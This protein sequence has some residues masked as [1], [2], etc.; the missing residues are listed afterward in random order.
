VQSYIDSVLRHRRDE[1]AIML[2]PPTGLLKILDAE[3]EES[4]YGGDETIDEYPDA[5]D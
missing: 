5:D 2:N 3:T 4:R 1:A